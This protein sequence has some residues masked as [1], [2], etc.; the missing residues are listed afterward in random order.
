M[1]K[2]NLL[3]AV[4]ALALIGWLNVASAAAGLIL[5]FQ[6]GDEVA[7]VSVTSADRVPSSRS[8]AGP[9][10]TIAATGK[11]G[12]LRWSRPLA[13][14]RM[15]HGDPDSAIAF[16]TIVPAIQV[17][18]RLSMTDAGGMLRWSRIVDSDMLLEADK[19]ASAL[20]AQLK[21]AFEATKS[22]QHRDSRR[23]RI[24]PLG[25][26][27]MPNNNRS[28]LPVAFR[29]QD[30][31][32]SAKTAQGGATYHVSGTVVNNNI[33]VRVFDAATDEFVVSTQTDWT[34]S[35]FD[36]DLPG[37][38]YVFEVDDN[39]LRI[40]SEYFYRK[41]YRTA[42]IQITSNT[43]LPLIPQ[44]DENGKFIL[45]AQIPCSLLHP[46]V[47]AGVPVYA[48]TVTITSADGTRVRRVRDRIGVTRPDLIDGP[49]NCPV[50]YTLQLSPGIYSIEIDIRGWDT[51]HFDSIQIGNQQIEQREHLFQMSER[52]LVW[53]GKIVDATDTP[54]MYVSIKMID[55]L[56]EPGDAGHI[57]FTVDPSG[58]FEFPYSPGWT[59]EFEALSLEPLS[60]PYPQF[61]GIK[62]QTLDA[63]PLPS[64]I[65][66]D[67][68]AV[69]S[70]ID[71]GLL[72]FVGDGTREHRYNILF[73]GDGYTDVHE[74]FTDTNGNGVWDGIV[75]HDMNGDGVYDPYDRYQIYGED[76]YHNFPMPDPSS[77]NEPFDDIND[78]GILSFDDPAEF[79]LNARDFMR[80]FLAAD[81][82]SGHK[83]AFNAYM[84]FE[85]SAES[86]FD[87]ATETGQLSVER[88][89]RYG[90]N[91]VQP[92]MLM[93]INRF[94]AMDRALTALPEVDMVVVLVNQTVYTFARGNVMISQP[95]VMVWPSG[96]S[97][98]FLDTFGMGPS[99]EMAHFVAVLCDEYFEYPGESPLHGNPS[100]GCPNTSYL[101][102]PNA[103]PWSNWI[104]PGAGSPTRNLDGSI[105]IYEG[106]QYYRG[107]AY[108]PSFNSTMNNL[109]RF[110][111]APSRDALETAVHTRLGV[112][113]DAADDSG[114]CARL[115][116]NAIRRHGVTC[117]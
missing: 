72:R 100:T 117:R 20:R 99:H 54:V 96:L 21:T 109:S 66:L 70:V 56:N 107:G 3:I 57:D 104:L 6:T 29:N 92:R 55:E 67:R 41:P 94:S 113:Q 47:Y 12:V 61:F 53:A 90:A 9:T 45:H 35:R 77:A 73:L 5:G 16:S 89:T 27:Q 101:N 106:A 18:D 10:W 81:F 1:C 34:N 38:R 23:S 50:S 64:K 63:G 43:E 83:Q 103:V 87:I 31:S 102:D 85:P 76:G 98:T 17:G 19:K 49:G 24:V 93:G 39:R 71:S 116:P 115:P 75:W 36:F 40:D 110:F 42:P 112:W 15:F 25:T 84:L 65:V 69:G 44:N 62:R 8:I 80:H 2:R 30:P 108:R 52:T 91:L 82:W 78:D 74:T 14:P 68:L 97:Q 11:D 95:G 86:G 26:Q 59:I 33:D 32:T 37:G 60:F 79:E 105:G 22:L 28:S 46:V 48:P 58:H 111:N 114:R 13:P 51:L 4:C 7:L 88:N